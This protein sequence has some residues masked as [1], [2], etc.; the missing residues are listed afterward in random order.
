MK[1]KLFSILLSASILASS[2]PVLTN[3]Q[4]VELDYSNYTAKGEIETTSTA[5]PIYVQGYYVGTTKSSQSVLTAKVSTVLKRVFKGTPERLLK[6]LA[7][8]V[9]VE[10]IEEVIRYIP[11]AGG[12][13]MKITASY[14]SPSGPPVVRAVVGRNGEI[15]TINNFHNTLEK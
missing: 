6:K 4:N 15:I 8:E 13:L 1:K 5:V 2:A 3:A 7:D 9:I 10:V 14:T 11:V 12:Q